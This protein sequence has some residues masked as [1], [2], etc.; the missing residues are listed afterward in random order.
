MTPSNPDAYI[1]YPSGIKTPALDIEHELDS[2]RKRY[3]I[4]YK[5][6]EAHTTRNFRIVLVEL[7]SNRTQ[8][9]VHA[10]T[11]NLWGGLLDALAIGIGPDPLEQELMGIVENA[12]NPQ[13]ASVTQDP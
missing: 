6:N 10:G 1:H 5:W 7:S 9:E 13:T 3:M 11:S 4:M 12:I 2:A 8:A